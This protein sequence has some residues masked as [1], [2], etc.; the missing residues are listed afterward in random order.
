M[1]IWQKKLELGNFPECSKT[2]SEKRYGG[3][4]SYYLTAIQTKTFF[5]PFPGYLKPSD[6]FF[7][8]LPGC[9]PSHLLHLT[10]NHYITT[11]TGTSKFS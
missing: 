6:G 11:L 1:F 10:I 8:E 4:P 5:T 9:Y 2:P 7:L 3:Y